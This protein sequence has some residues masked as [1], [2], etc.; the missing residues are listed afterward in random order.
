[1]PADDVHQI[2]SM[3]NGDFRKLG[4]KKVVPYCYEDFTDALRREARKMRLVAEEGSGELRGSPGITIKIT[5]YIE[6]SAV[7]NH[8]EN[9][10][11][12]PSSS[13]EDQLLHNGSVRLY[14]LGV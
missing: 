8:I 2:E 4:A 12:V 7:L 14:D 10:I 13:N 9:Y 6:F 11:G 3:R 1:M 5:D